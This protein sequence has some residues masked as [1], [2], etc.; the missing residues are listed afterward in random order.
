MQNTQ[1][2]VFFI[3]IHKFLFGVQRL[4]QQFFHVS[5]ITMLFKAGIPNG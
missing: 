2:Y 5:D 3:H 1:F 4:F